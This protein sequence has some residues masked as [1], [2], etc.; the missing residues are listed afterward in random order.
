MV[1]INVLSRVGSIQGE[2]EGFLECLLLYLY[3]A[4]F[5]ERWPTAS[6]QFRLATDD[7]R[8]HRSAMKLE[9]SSFCSPAQL[10]VNGKCFGCFGISAEKVEKSQSQRARAATQPSGAEH[11]GGG[12]GGVWRDGRRDSNCNLRHDDV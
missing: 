12:G 5:R 2:S 10:V 1:L 8:R 3:R 4:L 6:G 7:R 9:Q 11:N